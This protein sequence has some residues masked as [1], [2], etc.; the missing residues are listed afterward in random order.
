MLRMK[1]MLIGSAYQV[2]ENMLFYISQAKNCY[3]KGKSLIDLK[4]NWRSTSPNSATIIYLNKTDDGKW[5]RGYTFTSFHQLKAEKEYDLAEFMGYLKYSVG[6][7]Q[8]NGWISHDAE[9]YEI[10]RNDEYKDAFFPTGATNNYRID[11]KLV[12]I[13]YL[14]EYKEFLL[15]DEKIFNMH[16]DHL[17]NKKQSLESILKEVNEKIDLF[18]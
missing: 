6:Y 5:I 14:D 3:L 11:E 1:D 4:S 8:M 17:K 16:L 9:N 13:L 18:K 15:G 7:S 2:S 10:R 12:K